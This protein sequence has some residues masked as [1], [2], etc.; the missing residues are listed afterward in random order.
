MNNIDNIDYKSISNN[1][2][3]DIQKQDEI[4]QEE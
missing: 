3:Q 2:I 1:F 4:N